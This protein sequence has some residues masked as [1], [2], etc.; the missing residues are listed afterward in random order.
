[1]V[2]L[3]R[4]FS[5]VFCVSLL[6]LRCMVFIEFIGR[7]CWLMQTE[8]ELESWGRREKER[9]RDNDILLRF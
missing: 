3:H 1:M 2:E 5:W 9:D 6:I 4:V 7:I 8:R